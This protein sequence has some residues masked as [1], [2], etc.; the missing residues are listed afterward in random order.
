MLEGCCAAAYEHR[1]RGCGLR[2]QEWFPAGSC[3]A[4]GWRAH[5]QRLDPLLDSVPGLF[6]WEKL[7]QLALLTRE[8]QHCRGQHAV[9]LHNWFHLLVLV[10]PHVLVLHV[11]VIVLRRVC[12]RVGSLGTVLRDSQGRL[13]SRTED[14][15]IE[16]R[17]AP[18]LGRK[19]SSSSAA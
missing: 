3:E 8:F 12:S 4:S 14:P 1:G 9:V 5:L 17:G 13:L 7:S 15:Q 19:T 10:L 11:L 2:A 18:Y 6:H 16:I